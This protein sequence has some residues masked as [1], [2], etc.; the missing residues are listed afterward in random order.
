ML[1][2]SSSVNTEIE[3]DVDKWEFHRIIIDN[4]IVGTR[5]GAKNMTLLCNKMLYT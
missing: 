1:L 2:S 3:R 5:F 4:G